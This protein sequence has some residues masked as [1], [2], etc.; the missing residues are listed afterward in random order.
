MPIEGLTA[1]SFDI[2]ATLIKPGRHVSHREAPLGLLLNRVKRMPVTKRQEPATRVRVRPAS[3]F[4]G[5]RHGGL[6]AMEKAVR[7]WSLRTA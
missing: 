5:S 6:P 3:Q 7:G 2:T 4:L 1:D